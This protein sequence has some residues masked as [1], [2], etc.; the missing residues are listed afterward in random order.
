MRLEVMETHFSS[1]SVVLP[2]EG[3]KVQYAED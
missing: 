1:F 2:G 3:D